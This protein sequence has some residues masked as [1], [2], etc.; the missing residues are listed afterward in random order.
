MVAFA[1]AFLFA[2]VSNA[3][4]VH[5]ASTAPPTAAQVLARAKQAAGGAAVDKI[6]TLHFQEHVQVLGISGDGEEWDDL[7]TGRFA[8]FQNAGPAS[9]GEGFD[10]ATVWSQDATGLAH[11]TGS[12]QDTAAALSQAYFVSLSFWYPQRAASILHAAGAPPAIIESASAPPTVK[13]VTEKGKKYFVVSVT[14]GESPADIWIDAKTYLIARDVI[15][16]VPDR[17][18]RI[19]FSDYRKVNG[20]MIPFANQFQDAQGNSFTT[21]VTHVDANTSVDSRFAMPSTMPD[22]FSMAPGTTSTTF[23]IELINNHIFLDAKVNGQGPFRFIFDTGGTGILNP[24]V[25]EK[26]G[27]SPAGSMQAGGA[28]AGTVQTGFAWVPKVELGGATMTHQSFAV[29]P[30]GGVMGA[31]EGV[32][33]DGMVG[34]ETAARYIMTIDYAHKTMT[35]TMPGPTVKPAGTSVPFVFV[36]TVPEVPGAVDGVQGSFIVDTGNRNSLVVYT[37]FVDR[38]GLRAK[39]APKVAGVAGYGIG[40]PTTAQ[41]TRVASVRIGTIDVP[42]VVTGLSLDKTGALADPDISGNFG[43]G[44]LG[45]FTVTF[46][47]HNRIMYLAK[48]ADFDKS[49]ADDHSGLV[50]VAARSGI[51]A[52]GVLSNTPAAEAGIQ[53]G[54][55]IVTVNG[56]P[57]GDMGLLAIRS[58]LHGPPGTTVKLTVSTGS[59]T[60]DVTLTLREYV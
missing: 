6:H 56:T 11:P 42:N 27:I 20:A 60:R 31:V 25:A 8:S 10:G 48:N 45:R 14:S 19:D 15:R 1:I 36:Q 46:D 5:A 18:V 7:L 33:I 51:K 4:P 57:A 50:L 23:P 22:D 30:L 52:I 9:S 37:P 59:Q 21:T 2:L 49:P 32:H 26:L 41:L 35:L 58:L 34:W 24:D 38:N 53:T 16:A 29:L 12:A 39:Y 44:L 54:D 40:G 17:P 55:V 13:P 43:G 47:Y 28:G 3:S